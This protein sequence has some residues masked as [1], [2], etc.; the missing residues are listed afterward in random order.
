MRKKT[1]AVLL[2]MVAV[3][4]ISS[5]VAANG[6]G[7]VVGPA[8]YVDGDLY[9]TVLTPTDLSGTKAPAHTFDAIYV[10]VANDENGA[11]SRRRG[12]AWRPRLQRW[13]MAG[14]SVQR[15]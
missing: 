11:C 10:I 6:A 15:R 8:F 12:R 7:G 3:L 9:K 4:S 13:S 2:A 14:P 5:V 1:M